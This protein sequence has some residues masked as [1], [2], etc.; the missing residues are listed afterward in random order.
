MP[1][2]TQLNYKHYWILIAIVILGGILRLVN[3]D[4]KNLGIDEVLTAIFS[5]GKSYQNIPK[6]I[7]FTPADLQNI[8]RLN[9]ETSC[10]EIAQNLIKE[11]TH[12]PL[13]FCATNQWLKLLN[14]FDLDLVW[15][16]RSLPAILGIISIAL[17]YYLNRIA[18]SPL[19]GLM[20]AT[21]MAF[22]PFGVYLSQEARHY[23]LPIVL[24]TISLICLIKIA[25]SIELEKPEQKYFWFIWII[26]NSISFYVHYFCLLAYAAQAIILATLIFKGRNYEKLKNKN[27][28]IGAQ[29]FY[30]ILPLIFLLPWLPILIEHFTNPKTGW[31]PAP[32]HIIPLLQTFLAWLL[33]AIALPLENQPRGMQI[34]M[35]ILT[36]LFAIWFI[37]K[38]SQGL[39]S[40]WKDKN[41][42]KNTVIL[43]SF[44]A[45]VLLQFFVII[46]ILGKDITV[47]PR[48]HFIYYPAFCALL[49]A[50]L[51]GLKIKNKLQSERIIIVAIVGLISCILVINNIVLEKPYLPNLTAK[52]FARSSE[53]TMV[54][55]G[56]N[57]SN[58]VALG[59]SYGLALDRIRSQ[60]TA[61]YLAFLERDPSYNLMWQRLTQL[62]SSTIVNLWI[63]APGLRQKEYPPKL[64]IGQNKNCT[65]DP[66]NYYRVGIPY[67]LYICE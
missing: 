9:I 20:A 17:V 39:K 66:D 48:Y 30:L 12:P 46:Y 64:Q 50:S 18:F 28:T 56:Y 35:G 21:I 3:L 15:K 23:T 1:K 19:A 27:K 55:T 16:L 31:L 53:P 5:L 45:L 14:I 43:A 10:A 2:Q 24:I 65:L 59:I 60:S 54:V 25:R 11:S 49:G 62:K 33:V 67:Q 58:E 42:H 6:E 51:L 22:S 36:I 26:A 41:T 47:A 13:F 61:T 63:V 44:V 40:I 52:I 57:N 34:F 29:L 32:E 8:L 7:V 4:L 38:V 37:T